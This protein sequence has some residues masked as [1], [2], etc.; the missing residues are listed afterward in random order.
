MSLHRR[1]MLAGA[2]FT[3]V[4][5]ALFGLF[6]MA[7]VYTVEDRFFE[8]LLQQEAQAQ[9][10]HRSAHGRWG[11]TA[12]DFLVVHDTTASLPPDVAQVLAQEPGRRELAGRDG[13][14]YHLLP[15]ET[16]G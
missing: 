1:W 10:A 6:A 14:H 11:P 5:T 7:F 8:R 4:V 2:L 15:L 16:A 3:V 12:A 13:R 9:R